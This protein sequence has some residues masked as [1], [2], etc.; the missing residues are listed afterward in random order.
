VG[1]LEKSTFSYLAAAA[2]GP[3]AQGR[4]YWGWARDRA[5]Q[6]PGVLSNCRQ[7]IARIA[8]ISNGQGPGDPTLLIK[9][10]ACIVPGGEIGLCPLQVPRPCL[11]IHGPR[12]SGSGELGSLCGGDQVGQHRGCHIPG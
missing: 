2:P 3:A 5:V 12:L 1:F 6:D 4:R 9:L 10:D 7:W 8:A 11:H